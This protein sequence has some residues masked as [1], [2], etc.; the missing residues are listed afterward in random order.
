MKAR[1]AGADLSEM[2]EAPKKT[3]QKD[4]S[5]AACSALVDL[6]QKITIQAYEISR[7]NSKEIQD[8]VIQ[9]FG[10]DYYLNC[11]KSKK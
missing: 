11:Y 3:C 1:Q 4:M 5:P 8:K 7:Y 9:D 2:M 10:N 6:L